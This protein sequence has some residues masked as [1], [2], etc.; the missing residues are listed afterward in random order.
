ML[1][2]VQLDPATRGLAPGELLAV[3]TRHLGWRLGEGVGRESGVSDAATAQGIRRFWKR[4]P[5]HA[6]MRGVVKALVDQMSN[7]QI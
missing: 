2:E 7:G 3:A 4:A 6:E 1:D 5:D